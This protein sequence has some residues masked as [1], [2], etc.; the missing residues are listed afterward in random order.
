MPDIRINYDDI[1]NEIILTT[2]ISKQCEKLGE[3]YD[4]VSHVGL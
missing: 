4:V 2:Y 3:I 1:S